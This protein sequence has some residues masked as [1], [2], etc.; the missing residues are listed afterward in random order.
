MSLNLLCIYTAKGKNKC[1]DRSMK[2]LPP[3]LLGNCDRPTDQ[4]TDGQ[5]GSWGSFTSKNKQIQK[6]MQ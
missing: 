2:V 3:A 1:S 4:S 5:A 6:I